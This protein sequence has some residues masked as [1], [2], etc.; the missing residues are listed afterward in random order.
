MPPRIR[1]IG[2][3][4]VFP[5]FLALNLVLALPSLRREVWV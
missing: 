4:R 5:V 2:Q 1:V 3:Y